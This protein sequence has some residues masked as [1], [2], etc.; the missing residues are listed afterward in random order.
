MTLQYVGSL[1]VSSIQLGVVAAL[2]GISAKISGLQ[3]GIVELNASAVGQVNMSLALPPNVPGVAASAF[4]HLNPAAL[5]GLLNPSSW[6]SANAGLQADVALKLGLGLARIEI[7]ERLADQLRAGFDAGGIAEWAYTGT[8][9]GFGSELSFELERSTGGIHRGS[10]VSGLLI[11]CE[12]GDAWG[13]FGEGFNT[14]DPYPGSVQFVGSLTGGEVVTALRLPMLEIEA[15]LSELRGSVGALRS[16]LDLAFGMNLPAPGDLLSLGLSVDLDA[17]IESLVDIEVDI[18]AE[19]SAELDKIQLLLDLQSRIQATISGGGLSVWRYSGAIDAM[20]AELADELEDG[21]P[22]G[23]GAAAR[24]SGVALAC[25]SP[26]AWAAF[27]R[28]VP[29]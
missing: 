19:V 25:S 12:D 15:Y 22:G 16:Q 28:L 2:D 3:G 18:G 20:G 24:V 5:A 29:A 17:A 1:P 11:A 6:I 13:S 21:L 7:A 8:A 23:G 10:Q 26:T 14:G 9:Q 4:G 27:G